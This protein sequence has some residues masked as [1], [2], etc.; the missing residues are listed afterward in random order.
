MKRIYIFIVILSVIFSSCDKLEN[1]NDNTK[2]PAVVTGESLFTNAQKNVFDQMVSTNVNYNNFRLYVQQWTETTYPDESQYDVTTR[3]IPAN[4]WNVLYRDVLKDLNESAK[5][6]KATTYLASESSSVKKNKLAIVDILSAY[7]YSILV[8]T[9]GDVPYSEAL[10]LDKPL[11][12]YDDSYTIIKDLITRLDTSAKSLDLNESSFSTADNMYQGDPSL[13]R[14][15][16]YS[17]ELK[18]GML[19]SDYDKTTSKTVVERSA[20]NVIS[21]N[22]ENAKLVYAGA[23]PNTNPLYSDLVASGR[24]DFIPANTFVDTLN[25]LSDPRRPYYFT[26][27]DG[28]YVGGTYGTSNDYSSFSHIADQ[29]Q[30]ATFEGTILDYPEIEF[31]LAEAV[32][33]GYSVS[34]TAEQ[35]Y[36]NAITASI[37]YWGGST[38]DVATYLANPK[39]AYSTAEGNYKHKIGLQSWIALYNRGFEAWTQWRRLDYPKLVAPPDALSDIPTRII[40]PIPEQTLNSVN[41]KAASAAIGGDAVTTKLFWDKY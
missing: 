27:H 15:F 22:S 7:A 1:L 36:N 24:H 34:G 14:K 18:L 32:E 29:I 38:T 23:A 30:K 26:L 41:Y 16:A 28:V 8:E 31:L 5:V 11:P 37:L 4:H 39:V 19:L 17:I 10:N 2:D 6:I 3:A 21:S 12:K 20:P 33:L 35:H 25:S 40:Y 13:W 9:F